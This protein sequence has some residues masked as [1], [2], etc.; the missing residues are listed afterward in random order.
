MGLLLGR[1]LFWFLADPRIEADVTSQKL[2]AK[3]IMAFVFCE[4]LNHSVFPVQ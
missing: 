1:H 4:F 3:P 2:I